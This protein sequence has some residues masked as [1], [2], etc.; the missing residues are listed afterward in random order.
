LIFD[1]KLVKQLST[2]V[3]P[4][5]NKTLQKREL[6]K[7]VVLDC[8]KNQIT[9]LKSQI[10]CYD[11]YFRNFNEKPSLESLNEQLHNAIKM[12]NETLRL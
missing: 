7:K 11:L 9:F 1:A 5:L 10:M 8:L 4:A 12:Y 2:I 3:G 6:S